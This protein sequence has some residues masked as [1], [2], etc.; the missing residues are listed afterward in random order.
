MANFAFRLD[1]LLERGLKARF[2]SVRNGLIA[3]GGIRKGWLETCFLSNLLDVD[4]YKPLKDKSDRMH[5]SRRVFVRG[6]STLPS[7]LSHNAPMSPEHENRVRK[8]FLWQ[9]YMNEKKFRKNFSQNSSG[10]Q[11]VTFFWGY[12]VGNVIFKSI[13]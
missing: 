4:C 13:L 7:R 5:D 3:Q 2:N 12:N 6:W 9:Y 11:N 10:Q 8:T 1:T